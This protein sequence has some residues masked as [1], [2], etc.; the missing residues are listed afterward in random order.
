[1][2]NK[3]QGFP[4]TPRESKSESGVVTSFP[5]YAWAQDE[6]GAGGFRARSMPKSS[7]ARSVGADAKGSFD[8]VASATTDQST[9][10]NTCRC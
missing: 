2:S 8:S 6:K 3:N 9:K 10:Q 1:M 7:G 5:H 4:A